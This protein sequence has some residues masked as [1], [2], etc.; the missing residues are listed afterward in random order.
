[1][2]I[3]TKHRVELLNAKCKYV[4][5]I[6]SIYKKMKY[7][8][9]IDSCCAENLWLAS[10]LINRLECHC[11]SDLVLVE[12]EIKAEFLF[13]ANN[14]TLLPSGVYTASSVNGVYLANYTTDGS[15]T[16]VDVYEA[17]LAE[18]RFPYTT[19]TSGTTTYFTVTTNCDTTEIGEKVVIGGV[20]TI[21]LATPTVAGACVTSDC[22][23]CTEDKDLNKMY[24][25]LN[26][27][28]S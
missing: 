25:V 23:N 21:N 17:L 11:F 9:E 28:L 12:E 6:D 15:Q 16:E 3:Q 27:L 4:C 14:T 5:A 1:M 2:D 24:A 7:G 18:L 22:I 10:K 19:E 13:D 8:E 20:V 26:H